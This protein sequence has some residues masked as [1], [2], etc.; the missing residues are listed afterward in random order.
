MGLKYPIIGA[1]LPYNYLVGGGTISFC[2]TLANHG[3]LVMPN[4]LSHLFLFASNI[5]SNQI[6]NPILRDYL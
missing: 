5:F 6:V 3:G 4:S 2:K 1:T